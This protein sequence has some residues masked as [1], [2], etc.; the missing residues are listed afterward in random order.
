MTRNR[1][2]RLETTGLMDN[3]FRPGSASD[4]GADNTVYAVALDAS[5]NILIGGLF[6]FVALPYYNKTK[7]VETSG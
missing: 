4:L 5:G 3:T 6:S 2:A 1:I 7:K